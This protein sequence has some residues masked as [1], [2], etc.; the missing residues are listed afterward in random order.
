[1]SFETIRFEVAHGVAVLTLSRPDVLNSFNEAMHAEI[2]TALKTV[3]GDDGVRAL[4][5]TGEGRAFSAGQ[6]LSNRPNDGDFS[7]SDSLERN[8]N[9][10]VKSLRRLDIPVVCAVNGVAAGAGCSIALA[11]DI[12]LAA[13]SAEF[14]QA[15]VRI[16]LVP[17]AGSTYVLP[18]LIGP[19]RA[20]GFAMLGD[21]LPA[22]TA[23]EWGLIW[24][25][26]DDEE[27]MDEGLALAK[28]LAQQPTMALALMKRAFNQS[29]ANSLDRQLDLERD[30]Q[31]IAHQ[32]ED[33]A[34]GVAAFREK[35]PAVF[36]GR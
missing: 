26:V 19:A 32:T 2:R 10:L 23:A 8:Y 9:R 33:F 15:F 36:K 29:L 12:V 6:D 27:L 34:E 5:L 28:R 7:I 18:R 24:K 21:K 13:R 11:C 16:G 25:C 30:L 35:R 31:G 17:D 1:M 22:E 3:R 4:L 14:I 20:F